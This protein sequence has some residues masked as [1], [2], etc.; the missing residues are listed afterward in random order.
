V[1]ELL[2]ERGARPGGF[3]TEE[4]RVKG[5]RVGF[6]VA[7]FE[8]ELAVLAHVDRA[9]PPR[10]GRYGVDVGEFERVALPALAGKRDVFIVDELGKMELAS[11]AF[12]V[13]V[14]EL[15]ER[16]VAIVATAQLARHPFTDALKRARG[17]ERVRVSAGERDA[18][19]ERLA[20]RLTTPNPG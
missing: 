11:E 14:T 19:P 12:R 9:G 2:S 17:V 3:V 6:T 10:V 1:A 4:M 20:D 15:F 16:P 18:L 13:A 7:T 8:G 5:R